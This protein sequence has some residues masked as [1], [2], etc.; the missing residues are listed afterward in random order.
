MPS[1]VMIKYESQMLVEFNSL[2]LNIVHRYSHSFSGN[3]KFL[4]FV[5]I[6]FNQPCICQMMNFIL[7]CVHQVSRHNRVFNY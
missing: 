3:D 5:G 6:E 1:T 4:R 7:I 2:H